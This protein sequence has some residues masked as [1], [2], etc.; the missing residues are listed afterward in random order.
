MS[1][2]D[3]V[4]NATMVKKHLYSSTAKLEV[5]GYGE[6]V[7]EPDEARWIYKNT[8][9]KVMRHPQY[10]HLN[11]YICLPEKHPWIEKDRAWEIDS[12]VHGG[13]TWLEKE[14]DGYFWVGFDCLHSG[15]ISPGSVALE[16]RMDFFIKE[17]DKKYSVLKKRLEESRRLSKQISIYRDAV[18]RNLHF[19]I[20]E[21]E[22]LVD[23]ML[24][25]K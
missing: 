12:G 24:D 5:F 8:L 16:K 6:W 9:C 17:L 10:G 7:E 20:K 23:E 15:D 21:C 19:C 22:K 3:F 4:K 14:D 18:Y 13:I 2:T 25:S 11:G 1:E